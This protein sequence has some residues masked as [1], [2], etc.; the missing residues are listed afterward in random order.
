MKSSKNLKLSSIS[1]MCI[2]SKLEV[3]VVG[4]KDG[5]YIAAQQSNT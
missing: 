1:R 5:L 2:G 3:Q 4:F